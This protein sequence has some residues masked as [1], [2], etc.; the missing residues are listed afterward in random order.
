MCK[1]DSRL[2]LSASIAAWALAAV[3]ALGAAPV[4]FVCDA[5]QDRVVRLEDR[6]GSGRIEAAA[7]GE[8]LPFYDDA[9]PGPD[10]S[11]PSGLALAADGDLY[12]VDGGT[13]D[14]ILALRDRNGDGDA[15]DDGEHRVVYDAS[16]SG[17]D[18]GT[19]NAIA[20][21]SDGRLYVADDG[22]SRGLILALRDENGDGDALD[23]GEWRVLYDS[24]EAAA[25]GEPLLLEDPEALAVD[26]GGRLWAADATLQ[27]VFAL[28][29]L[30]GNSRF[31]GAGEIREFYAPEAPLT[32][33]DPEAIAIDPAGGL[34]VTDEDT[35]LI[36]HLQ[37]LDGD[38]R[39]AGASEVR[40]VVAPDAPQALRD[41]NDLAVSRSGALFVLD[42]E[43]DQIFRVS[44][45]DG[46]GRA[47]SA[48]EVEALLVAGE[49]VVGTPAGIAVI[50]DEPAPAPALRSLEPSS[51]PLA[52]GTVVT[53]SGRF[54]SAPTA[55]RFGGRAA[56]LI[57]SGPE[58]IRCR[59]PAAASAGPVDVSVA[60]GAV[61]LRL[62][63]AYVY[64]ASSPVFVRGDANADRLINL[65]DAVFVLSFLFLGGPAPS[66]PDAADANDDGT[67]SISDPSA[68]LGHLFLGAPPPPPPFPDA[69]EDPSADALD[70]GA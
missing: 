41:T 56:E 9:S 42:G 30:D 70:C 47:H 1:Q 26:S 7:P 62:P 2:V 52:G 63:L 31:A 10:L 33:T 57:E 32:L 55:I 51:G 13:L 24:A 36:V 53:L 18:L 4:I 48:G 22:R 12:M 49:R 38:G 34:Y 67:V 20:F 16:S 21:G 5:T 54:P 66:C 28:S 37:D 46:D 8:V 64:I 59:A 15:N 39:A 35:G 11:T 45:L 50:E 60:L 3:S 19:A 29:D 27:R 25:A 17:P 6:D 44:D 40:V 58:S 43:R 14:L 68:V 61:E 69:G 65:S 23:E